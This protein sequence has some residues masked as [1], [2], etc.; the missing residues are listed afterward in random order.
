MWEIERKE[1]EKR[2]QET[3]ENWDKKTRFEKIKYI[4]EKRN[5]EQQI[6]PTT[7][8]ET[9]KVWRKEKPDNLENLE[10]KN[11][12]KENQSIFCTD[13]ERGGD[14][15]GK[16]SPAIPDPLETKKLSPKK[17]QNQRNNNNKTTPESIQTNTTKNNKTKITEYFEHPEKPISQKRIKKHQ[18]KQKLTTKNLPELKILK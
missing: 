8:N 10:N 6:P 18:Q 7:E 3:L 15:T 11:I 2:R 9:W 12:R 1:R 13:L 16:T 17:N 5:N 14:I 4:K